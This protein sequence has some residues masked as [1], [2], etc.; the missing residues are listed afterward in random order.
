MNIWITIP[1]GQRVDRAEETVRKWMKTGFKIAVCTWD[2]ETDERL[3]PLVDEIWYTTEIYSFA[4]FQNLM[5]ANLGDSKWDCIICGADDLWPGFG[6]EFIEETVKDYQ[7][8]VIWVGDSGENMQPTHP[9]ITREWYDKYGRIFDEGF[10]HNFCD[11]D[12]AVRAMKAGELIKH[13]CISFEHR[14]WM[15][16]PGIE[17][18]SVYDRGLRFFEH[19]QNYFTLK[20][21]GYLEKHHLGCELMEV[22]A[23]EFSPEKDE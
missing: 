3:R 2:K 7:G 6:T 8:K 12:L 15:A 20:H 23:V 22:P 5:A 16:T 18:D 21:S 10:K 9:I 17:K 14:H 19:D 1:T 13:F 11:T 4:K